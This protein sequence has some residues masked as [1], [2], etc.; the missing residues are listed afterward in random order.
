M[1]WLDFWGA[2]MHTGIYGNVVLIGSPN[3]TVSKF[4]ADLTTA[5]NNGVGYGIE[6]TQNDDGRVHVHINLV[7]M[8]TDQSGNVQTGGRHYVQY[9]GNYNY[10]LTIWTS[11]NNQASWNTVYSGWVFSHPDTW[12]LAYSGNWLQTSQSSQW[13]GDVSIASDTT[14][15][16]VNL[17]GENPAYD[18][19]V[20]YTIDQV[21][22]EFRPWA[23]RKSQRWLSCNRKTGFTQIRKWIDNPSPMQYDLLDWSFEDKDHSMNINSYN[24]V[25]MEYVEKEGYK[26]LHYHSDNLKVNHYPSVNIE[27]KPNTTYIFS[28][29]VYAENIT[30]LDT[31]PKN[32]VQPY[33][34]MYYKEKSKF[35]QYIF[36]NVVDGDNPNT[37]GWAFRQFQLTT[38]D[39][40]DE[41][42]VNQMFLLLFY[43][44]TGDVY[45]RDMHLEIGGRNL[46]L[47][48]SLHENYDDWEAVIGDGY[49]CEF[50]TKENYQCLH[51]NSSVLT[52]KTYFSKPMLKKLSAN[53]EYTMS[54]WYWTEN[55][56]KGTTNY[57]IMNCYADG[58][59]NKDGTAH[60]FG[61]KSSNM[62]IN[63]GGWIY[64]TNTFTTPTSDIWDNARWFSVMFY[65][66][67]FTGDIYIR[68]LK[69]E[70]GNKATDWTPALEDKIL[71]W[72]DIPKMTEKG[73]TNKGT[74]RIRHTEWKGQSRIGEM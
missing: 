43:G 57:T 22:T 34:G 30:R 24:G 49:T 20:V 48:S 16:M 50:V 2:Y 74:S 19:S 13:E 71:S 73:Q 52:Q 33:F 66:R 12:Y 41:E 56:V 27:I 55:I 31:N 63:T 6:F 29:W 5:H 35:K 14:H 25:T 69:I 53:T 38:D 4:G 62:N 3:N 60:W 11:N 28:C 18:M 32:L 68:D 64:F 9:G 15:V 44:F 7:A 26:C 61:V 36:G 70:K 39:M 42:I 58:N 17:T 37:N 21:I 51:I 54:G 72:E 40:S 23:V 8:A 67:D 47:N 65:A 46:L 1:A 10:K 45:L 59:Y